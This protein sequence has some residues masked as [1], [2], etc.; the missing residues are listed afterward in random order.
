MF[1]MNRTTGLHFADVDRLV[2]VLH[3]LTDM[4]NSVLVIE[5]NMDVI[6]NADYI[7]DMGPS[8]WKRWGQNCRYG[9]P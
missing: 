5:H 3:H 8:K 9:N 2:K 4:G 6:K 1:W 7:I